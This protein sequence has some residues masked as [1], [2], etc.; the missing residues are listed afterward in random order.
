M[1][2]RRHPGRMGRRRKHEVWGEFSPAPA[3]SSAGRHPP[4]PDGI[5]ATR[6]GRTTW[7]LTENRTH[8]RAHFP[9]DSC[10][11]MHLTG[12]RAYYGEC[13]KSSQMIVTNEVVPIRLASNHLTA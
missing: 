11:P 8:W 13:T 6:G 9:V 5:G 2:R 4:G 10:R 7:E 12:M 3:P 1:D